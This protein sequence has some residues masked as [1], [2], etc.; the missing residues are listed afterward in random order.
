MFSKAKNEKQVRNN[1][2]GLSA[3]KRGCFKLSSKKLSF[4]FKRPFKEISFQKNS[5]E[6]FELPPEAE[7]KNFDLLITKYLQ[8]NTELPVWWRRRESNPRP[9]RKM[10]RLYRLLREF[11]F[12]MKSSS[13]RDLFTLSE[14]SLARP[15][16]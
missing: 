14:K 4:D 12:L 9:K 5:V 6:R 1:L 10:I 15:R 2:V 13:L 7:P 11:I 3:P 16:L 8:K